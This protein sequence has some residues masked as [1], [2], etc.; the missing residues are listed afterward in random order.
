[1]ATPPDLPPQRGGDSSLSGRK[2]PLHYE[3]KGAMVYERE[4][5]PVTPATGTVVTPGDTTGDTDAAGTVVPVTSAPTSTAAA[6]TATATV[7]VTA[8]KRPA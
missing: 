5:T 3:E 8:T 4:V 6:G 2:T 7:P 1:M